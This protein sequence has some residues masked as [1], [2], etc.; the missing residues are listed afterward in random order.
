MAKNRR[1]AFIKLNVSIVDDLYVNSTH[2]EAGEDQ[3]LPL[4]VG[5]ALTGA[6]SRDTPRAKYIN[7]YVGEGWLCA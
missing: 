6:S 3:C 7:T 5:S 2:T 1:R 4:A